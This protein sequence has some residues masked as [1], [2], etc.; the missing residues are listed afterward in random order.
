MSVKHSIFMVIMMSLCASAQALERRYM[1]T[2]DD[3]KWTL[4]E[5]SSIICRLEHSIPR[6]GKAVFT[7][8]A[9]RGLKLELLSRHEFKR[10]INVELRSETASWNSRETR[11]VLARFET[12]GRRTLFKIPTGIAEQTFYELRQGY[13]PGFLFYDDYPLVASL[14]SVR[15]GEVEAEFTRCTGQLYARNF[16]DVRV[17]SIH[18]EPDN[19][20]ASVREEETAFNRMFDYLQIDN[21]ISEIVV[22]GHAD[23][24]GQA[25]YNEGLSERRAWYVYDL[26]VARGIDSNLLRVDY[27]GDQKPVSKGSNKKALAAN[28]RVTVELRR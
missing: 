13:Q 28:R 3:S 8:E 12:S 25:C 26:L 21:D 23:N 15:F 4:T 19:E 24:T 14:S 18:F 7:Q 9:G 20:F 10:G 16:A 17:S 6:F 22:T 5:N 11:V 27:A 2:M 1:A